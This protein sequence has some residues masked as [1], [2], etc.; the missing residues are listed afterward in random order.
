MLHELDVLLP[1]AELALEEDLR[2]LDVRPSLDDPFNALH[3]ILPV[4]LAV[5]DAKPGRHWPTHA[6]NDGHQVPPFELRGTVGRLVD[7]AWPLLEE[8]E[9]LEVDLMVI[10]ED[11]ASLGCKQACRNGELGV[12]VLLVDPLRPED[13]DLRRILICE[14]ACADP[15]ESC[16][17]LEGPRLGQ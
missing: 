12:R 11:H 14:L 4:V 8:R 3:H 7:V 16:L 13:P 15:R 10:L 6:A 17:V 2:L 1:D 5:P 9:A